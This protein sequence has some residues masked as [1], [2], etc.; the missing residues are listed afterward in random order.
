MDAARPLALVGH[1]GHGSLADMA[2]E[3][4]SVGYVGLL[5]AGILIWAEPTRPLRSGLAGAAAAAL[6]AGAG[7]VGGL[8]ESVVH[9]PLDLYFVGVLGV[10]AWTL[11][12]HAAAEERLVRRATAVVAAAWLLQELASATI[13]W[14]G[15]SN[16]CGF[17]ASNGYG[18]S[19]ALLLI[20]AAW[21][22]RHAEA[23]AA[24][25]QARRSSAELDRANRR[26]LDFART[27]SDWFWEQDADLRFTYVSQSVGEHS[28]LSPGDHFGKTRR[29]T[30]PGGVSDEALAEHEAA[31]ARP[32]PFKDFR[33]HRPGPDGALRCLAITGVPVFDGAGRFAGY[34][35]VGRDLTELIAAEQRLDA[36]RTRLLQ[37]VE[38]RSEGLAFWDRYDRLVM[39]HQASR[40][41]SEARR[42]GK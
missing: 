14:H 41:R 8:P 19:L 24:I 40:Q 26:L 1:P 38:A 7:T 22:R 10:A 28:T 35:G 6:W 15:E 34:R 31:L 23:L 42:G 21:R 11:W 17:V 20:V 2:A 29:E 4:L 39:C 16:P 25:E 9:L 27:S 32:E 37:A 36:T 12:T 30:M 18:D 33:I 5:T 3:F 13:G